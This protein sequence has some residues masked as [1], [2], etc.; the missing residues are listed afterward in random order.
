MPFRLASVLV[1][2]ALVFPAP[3]FAQANSLAGVRCEEPEVLKH[4]S[5][6]MEKMSFSD[7]RRVA[8]LTD[9]TRVS[10]PKTVRATANTLVCSLTVQFN[11]NGQPI[12]QRGRFTL[13]SHSDGRFSAEFAPNY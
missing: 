13:R 9:N 7:G 8:S 6:T 3:A 5:E 12:S 4:I 11:Y 1:A 10:N 2:L